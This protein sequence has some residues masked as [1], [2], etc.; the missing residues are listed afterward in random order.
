MREP[1]LRWR[2]IR[3]VKCDEGRP[4]CVRCIKAG[5]TCEGYG[6][7]SKGSVTSTTSRKLCPRTH[8]ER[9]P[10]SNQGR[11]RANTSTKAKALKSF[12]QSSI[13][14]SLNQAGSEE[15]LGGI[16]IS[17]TLS[18][19]PQS[20]AEERALLAW[21]FDVTSWKLPGTFPSEF[22]LALVPQASYSE[23][24]V[25]YGALAI[26]AAHRHQSLQSSARE[27]RVEDRP[28]LQAYTKAI[29]Y[30]RARL[31]AGNGS[32]AK[33]A[34]ITCVL[35][36]CLDLVQQRCLSA[37]LHLQGGLMIMAKTFRESQ[38]NTMDL[39]EQALLRLSLQMNH[40]GPKIVPKLLGFSQTPRTMPAMF[41]DVVDARSHLDMIEAQIA[42]LHSAPLYNID[43]RRERICEDLRLWL[44]AYANSRIE[45]NPNL[46]ERSR[47][48]TIVLRMC[49]QMTVISTEVCQQT[50]SESLYDG[51]SSR[52]LCIIN[53]ATKMWSAVE[54]A[55]LMRGLK[56]PGDRH[57]SIIDVGWIPATYFVAIRCR[58]PEIRSRAV[59][60]LEGTQ[61]T[62]GMWNA[63]MCVAV[64]KEVMRL[65]GCSAE[66]ER[67][68]AEDLYRPLKADH[69]S[70]PNVPESQRVSNIEM[71]YVDDTGRTV[72]LKCVRTHSDGRRGQFIRR[73]DA[74][75]GC[76]YGGTARSDV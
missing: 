64:A 13:G 68:G 3:K 28:T 69:L 35:F 75:T 42:E 8:S 4:A 2:R 60:L 51:H 50:R 27:A 30:A 73:Y 62:E 74:A 12:D 9:L 23:P 71:S 19:L 6:I 24:A 21:Y 25:L 15:M 72:L 53:D 29:S 47:G 44:R 67:D 17:Q 61:H 7:W 31:T 34:M 16:M 40:M 5:R 76:W 10:T 22:W 38:D 46:P 49:Y 45:T 43:E 33:V 41:H 18:D 59:R 26:A 37:A 66:H 14:T 70:L 63:N 57:A 1:G 11:L 36:V 52:F 32:S 48:A 56:F 65:E 39:I 20:P 54:Q 55:H 58:V